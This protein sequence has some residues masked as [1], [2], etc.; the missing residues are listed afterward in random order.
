MLTDAQFRK[1]KPADRPLKLGDGRGLHLFVT[2][3]G[4]KLWRYWY[5]VA[6]CILRV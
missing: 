2:P 4:G 1:V 3:A 6:G 5:R